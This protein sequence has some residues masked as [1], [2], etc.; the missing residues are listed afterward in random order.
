MEEKYYAVYSKDRSA[1]M[2]RF[3]NASNKNVSS[4]RC[5]GQRVDEIDNVLEIRVLK[6][7]TRQQEY[8]DSGNQRAGKDFWEVIEVSKDGKPLYA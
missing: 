5:Y 6:S 2:C 4:T 1:V 8:A 7:K 3:K